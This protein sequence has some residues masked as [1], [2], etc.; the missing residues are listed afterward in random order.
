MGDRALLFL[1]KNTLKK[2][3]LEIK[4]LFYWTLHRIC[5]IS[6]LF[7]HIARSGIS[8]PNNV[9]KCQQVLWTAVQAMLGILLVQK[10]NSSKAPFAGVLEIVSTGRPFYLASAS[11]TCITPG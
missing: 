6:V 9:S 8:H 5:F 3:L 1:R 11:Q 7:H 10:H 2:I 4:N